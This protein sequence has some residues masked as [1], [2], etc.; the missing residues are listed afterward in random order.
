MPFLLFPFLPRYPK[1][2]FLGTEK[3]TKPPYKKFKAQVGFDG[4]IPQIKM[5]NDVY[6]ANINTLIFFLSRKR[7]YQEMQI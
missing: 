2:Y 7:N 5:L 1:P 3:F 6:L 4:F